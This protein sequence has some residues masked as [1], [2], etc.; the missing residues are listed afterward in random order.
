MKHKAFK[1]LCTDLDTSIESRLLLHI[2]ADLE[3]IKTG[4]VVASK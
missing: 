4:S 3:K 1:K 2:D